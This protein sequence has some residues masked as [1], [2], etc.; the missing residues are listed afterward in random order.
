MTTCPSDALGETW[1]VE[2]AD[3]V[4]TVHRATDASD[5][6]DLE[7]DVTEAYELARRLLAEIENDALSRGDDVP[8]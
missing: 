7:M 8:L 6:L 2:L 4:L 3:G 5:L 1:R